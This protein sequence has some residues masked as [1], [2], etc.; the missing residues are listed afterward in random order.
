[1]CQCPVSGSC[2]F[3]EDEF[4]NL[5]FDKEEVSMPCIGLM[6]FSP[7]IRNWQ[8]VE[9]DLCQCPVSGSCLFHVLDG[10]HMDEP[11][12]MCQCPVSGSCLF[13]DSLGDIF[14]IE[15]IIVSMPC[16]GLMSFSLRCC[17]S[18][19]FQVVIRCQCPVSGSCLFHST[20]CKAQYLC[21]FQTLFF[22]VFF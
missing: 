3:H 14:Q 13:H 2:L 7:T 4:S 22:Y 17:Q 20:P 1:M 6:S 11:I 12:V 8:R 15:I 10:P 16:I 9:D 5:S 21:G 18:W 19:L